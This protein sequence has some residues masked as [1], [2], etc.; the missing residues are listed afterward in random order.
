MAGGI[1]PPFKTLSAGDIPGIILLGCLVVFDHEWLKNDPDLDSQEWRA[2]ARAACEELGVLAEFEVIPDADVTVIVS[3]SNRPSGE[4][5]EAC[6]KAV[7]HYRWTGRE[8]PS[9]LKLKT[10]YEDPFAQYRKPLP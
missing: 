2:R 10:G 3:P 9:E 8:I 5:I 1:L 6:V 4:Q 7:L